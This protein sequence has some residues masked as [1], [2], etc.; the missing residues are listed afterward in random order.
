MNEANEY[1]AEQS[2][3]LEKLINELERLTGKYVAESEKFYRSMYEEASQTKADI[4]GFSIAKNCDLPKLA[5][6]E[7]CEAQIH[8][9]LELL[10][11]INAKLNSL[12]ASEQCLL[13]LDHLEIYKQKTIDFCR[14]TVKIPTVSRP[15]DNSKG[16][17]QIVELFWDLKKKL[18]EQQDRNLMSDSV[19]T[20]T[21]DT[22]RELTGNLQ[23][24]FDRHFKHNELE[25]IDF[26]QLI[27]EI[28]KCVLSETTAKGEQDDQ[29]A[30]AKKEIMFKLNL[31]IEKAR[32]S[33][34]TFE[35]ELLKSQNDE[36]AGFVEK[37][38][39]TIEELNL[40]RFDL[41]TDFEDVQFKNF[42]RA[43]NLSVESFVSQ[44]HNSISDSLEKSFQEQCDLSDSLIAN[45]AKLTGTV[46]I[47][48]LTQDRSKYEV[49]KDLKVDMRKVN[50]QPRTESFR[51][52][53]LQ[54]KLEKLK[55]SQKDR[56]EKG[57]DLMFKTTDLI[58]V[59]NKHKQTQNAAEAA[60]AE[61]ADA[62]DGMFKIKVNKG[63]KINLPSIYRISVSGKQQRQTNKGNEMGEEKLSK[64]TTSSKKSTS[65]AADK[66][67]EN[68]EIAKK[69][70]QKMFKQDKKT[71]KGSTRRNEKKEK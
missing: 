48:R 66:R 35:D 32:I 38:T 16:Y 60:E 18:G 20:Q 49:P 15:N 12:S 26:D 68:L 11:Q 10:K 1:Q 14:S 59:I 47:K 45:L 39:K 58:A 19:G 29:K 50:I 28:T 65:S 67:A 70:I 21:A 13:F 64:L 3:D 5:D 54:K 71:K 24:T 61:E 9:L 51:R 17:S 44:V 2:K 41:Q 69:K 30:S 33:L 56:K 25:T 7:A 27:E 37:T 46:L 8:Q 42:L 23:T 52:N 6:K 63:K 22:W 62:N 43:I 55:T 4:A 57:S 36:L 53:A 40:H 31:I 34:K